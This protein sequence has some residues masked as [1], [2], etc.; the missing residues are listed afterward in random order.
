MPIFPTLK[1]TTPN[2]MNSLKKPY[3]KPCMQHFL[4]QTEDPVC[5]SSDHIP[6]ISSDGASIEA[7]R[8]NEGFKNDNDFFKGDDNPGSWDEPAN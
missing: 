4:V 5:S 1:I 3:E 6:D 7:S 2:I 8:V